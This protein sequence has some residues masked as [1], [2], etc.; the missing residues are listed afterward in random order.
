MQVGEQIKSSGNIYFKK[1][2]FVNA[3]RKYKKALRY[4][5]KLHD[6]NEMTEEIEKKVLNAEV[7]CLLNRFVLLSIIL[8]IIYN[9]LLI[10]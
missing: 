5:N 2:D 6:S 8:T 7:P 3:G 9:S 4:L 10:H 1:E